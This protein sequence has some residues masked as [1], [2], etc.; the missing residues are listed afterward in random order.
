MRES[1]VE[2]ALVKECRLRG[3]PCLKLT[4]TSPGVPDRLIVLPGGG[5]VFVEVK[6]PGRRPRAAQRRWHAALA[7]M[8]HRVRVA[9]HPA[10]ARALVAALDDMSYTGA[11]SERTAHPKGPLDETPHC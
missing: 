10:G 9:D 4:P 2:A 11:D 8:G 5:H 3:L 6:A 7:D 1:T